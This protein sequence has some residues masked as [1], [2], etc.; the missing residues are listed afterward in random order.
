MLPAFGAKADVSLYEFP[1][2]DF[3]MDQI[4]GFSRELLAHEGGGAAVI[5]DGG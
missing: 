2:Y 5:D 3:F 1:D 4:I